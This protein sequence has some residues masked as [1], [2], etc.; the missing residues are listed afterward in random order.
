MGFLFRM[1]RYRP[2]S[3]VVWL[4][5][6]LVGMGLVYGLLWWA[7]EREEERMAT[8]GAR[9]P[10]RSGFSLAVPGSWT[11]SAGSG[12]FYDEG[13]EAVMTWQHNPWKR[14]R[15]RFGDR[16]SELRQ[17]KD[18]A[19]QAEY[20]RLMKLGREW[21]ARILARYPELAVKEDRVI[22]AGENGYLKLMDL[23]SRDGRNASDFPT[24]YREDLDLKGPLDQ[25]A[26]KRFMEEHRA[27]VEQLREIGLM[28]DRSSRGMVMEP[29]SFILRDATS[30][31][32]FL[33]LDA[34]MA[35]ARGD[36]AGALESLRAAQGISSHL[37]GIE[38]ADEFHNAIANNL[39]V[40]IREQAMNFI[41]PELPADQI[42]LAAWRDV[43]VPRMPQPGDH[44]DALRGTWNVTLLTQLLP[45]MA[46]HSDPSVPHDSDQL[47]ELYT[48]QMLERVRDA[49]SSPPAGI[50]N[51]AEAPVSVE[52][53]S[54]RSRE[55]AGGLGMMHGYQ[56]NR[57][58]T[59][60][61]AYAGMSQAAFAIMSGQPVPVDPVSGLRYGWDPT[62]RE[63]SLPDSPIY[64]RSS[65]MP[66]TVPKL[67]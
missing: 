11:G 25:K 22:P 8:R 67:R 5:V 64:N 23:L 44:A 21:H 51:P 46:M 37:R 28:P 52:H 10:G 39:N 48:R 30:G 60:Q 43:A 31:G 34:R 40:R 55:V 15:I 29:W 59:S 61:E 63:L 13:V 26:A 53:L 54:W 58:W 12:G 65:M 32:E 56:M 7:G 20:K 41:L 9:S 2:S 19:D 4:A 45:A 38:G 47:V 16:L 24:L 6:P 18:P 14:E 3:R 50:E 36:V 62:K 66:I 35:A 42:D 33:L 17:S 27:L 57:G 1:M 49:E